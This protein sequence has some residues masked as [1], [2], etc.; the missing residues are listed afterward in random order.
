MKK[1]ILTAFCLIYCKVSFAQIPL[2]INEKRIL[3]KNQVHTPIFGRN[4]RHWDLLGATNA[5]YNVPYTSS[6]SAGFANSMWIGGL[7]NTNTL[8]VSANT[9]RQ[10]GAD[11]WP[12]PIDT[13]NANY[14]PNTVYQN[15]WKVD[16]NDITAFATAY[17]TGSVT[18]GTYT[19][20]VDMQTYPAKETGNLMRNMAPFNDVNNDGNYSPSQGD[21]PLIKGHQQILSIYNDNYT[22]H[23]ETNGLP[24]GIEIHER[25]YAYYEPTANDSMK[26]INYTTFYNFEIYNR[27]TNNYHDVFVCDWSDADLGYYLNDYIGSDTINKFVYQYNAD[28]TEIG[29]LP[30]LS[31]ALINTNCSNDGIDNNHNGTIDEPNE[32][33]LMD[34]ATFYNNNI[35]AFPPATTNPNSAVDYYNY[36]QG[37]WKDNSPQTFGGNAYGGTLPTSYVY[38]GNPETQTGWTEGTAGNLKGDRRFLMSS[39]P[40]NFP[41]QS[42][43]EWGYAIVFSLDTTSTNNTITKFNTIVKRDV[44]NVRYYE[45]AHTN[46]QCQ[47][48]IN[49]GLKEEKLLNIVNLYPNPGK[50]VIYINLNKNV[51]DATIT[52]AD[53]LG[54]IIKTQSIKST[55]QTQINTNDLTQGIYL[56]TIKTVNEKYTSKWIR[57]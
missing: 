31:H 3:D 12:G 24:M 5:Q 38:S 36:I 46:S 48:I 52:I 18:A 25:S 33:F 55:Y 35:G 1:I 51:N 8:H 43:I 17:N 9:Y 45:Q 2:T 10:N 42:K 21:Y 19:I 34:K 6:V 50:D 28:N 23:S 57:Q 37:F 16:C 11:F 41:A 32:H 47:P 26:A 20:P 7:D 56:I 29:Y 13:I 4:N 15:I 40:F 22:T 14:T 53:M 44:R 39:G 54:R 30:V 27:S 49:V